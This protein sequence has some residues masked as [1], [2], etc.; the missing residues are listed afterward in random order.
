MEIYDTEICKEVTN[1]KGKNY[2]TSLWM[3]TSAFIE[4]FLNP[5][6]VTP[7]WVHKLGI[8]PE[9]L[10]FPSNCISGL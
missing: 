2:S 9:Y 1:R 4:N 3:T 10:K 7:K 6:L 5:L 8:Q